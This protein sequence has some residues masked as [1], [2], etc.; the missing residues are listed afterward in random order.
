MSWLTGA[1]V[2][3]AVVGAAVTGAVAAPAPVV[4]ADPGCDAFGWRHPLCGGGAWG[5]VAD[6]GIPGD[7]AAEGGIPAPASV[8]NVDGSLSPPGMPG[9]V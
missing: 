5:P 4:Q 3:V 6:D 8:P 7:N 1:A 2:A 9:D